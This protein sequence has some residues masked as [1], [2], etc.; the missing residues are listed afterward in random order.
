MSAEA[1]GEWLTTVQQAA[2]TV[3]RVQHP[4]LK[5]LATRCLTI[6]TAV[7]PSDRNAPDAPLDADFASFL[8]ML[9]APQGDIIEHQYGAAAGGGVGAIALPAPGMMMSDMDALLAF[10]TPA[11]SPQ[12][13]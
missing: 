10:F 12:P 11:G 7:A 4:L 1:S 9:A 6:I 3:E 8:E 13:S 2:T 5:G